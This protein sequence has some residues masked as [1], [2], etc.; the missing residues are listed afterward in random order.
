MQRRCSHERDARNHFLAYHLSIRVEH[1]A[2]ACAKRIFDTGAGRHVN[3]QTLPLDRFARNEFELVGHAFL[4]RDRVTTAIAN[5]LDIASLRATAKGD[6][7]LG[8]IA[9]EAEVLMDMPE[10]P[11]IHAGSIERVF[12]GGSL[13]WIHPQTRMQHTDDEW[14]AYAAR[15]F[16][17][18]ARHARRYIA[19]GRLVRKAARGNNRDRFAVAFV[20]GIAG[21]IGAEHTHIFRKLVAQARPCGVRVMVACDQIHGDM[22]IV[23][24]LEPLQKMAMMRIARLIGVELVARE[25][26]EVDP[27]LKSRVDHAV[28]RL[29]NRSRKAIGPLWRQ[30]AQAAERRTQMDVA[31]MNECY[32]LAHIP[33][34]PDTRDEGRSIR[35]N[36]SE[37]P[38]GASR[39]PK[40]K[41]RCKVRRRL[42]GG[43]EARAGCDARETMW[44]TRQSAPKSEKRRCSCRTWCIRD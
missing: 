7:G 9:R 16:S 20:G 8:R 1:R 42:K 24:A 18:S 6:F 17:R 26:H 33:S 22:G 2:N 34:V 19:F 11:I 13:V 14:N 41:R 5:F 12:A 44:P 38:L 31:R 39:C 25:Q 3:A 27:A 40:K 21:L 32:A 37:K 30:V 36:D 15:R 29:G 23:Q 43:N 4:K 10:R 28:V 35:I